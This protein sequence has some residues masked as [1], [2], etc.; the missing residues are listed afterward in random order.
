M[1][2]PLYYSCLFIQQVYIYTSHIIINGKIY[3]TYQLY[4]LY[5]VIYAVY[6]VASCKYILYIYRETQS[7]DFISGLLQ[8]IYIS[9][10]S[11]PI[12]FNIDITQMRKYVN[13]SFMYN[14]YFTIYIYKFSFHFLQFLKQIVQVLTIYELKSQYKESIKSG[15]PCK[16]IFIY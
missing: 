4:M 1:I 6:T 11:K 9:K 8:Y 5:I 7:R 2:L 14:S 10:S 15:T 16:Y 13:N 12:S 3:F